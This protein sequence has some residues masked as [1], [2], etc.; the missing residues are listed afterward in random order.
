MIERTKVTKEEAAKLWF[1]SIYTKKDEMLESINNFLDK[2][3][4]VWK[5]RIMENKS[6]L[7]I[8]PLI[9]L[10]Y[11]I[12]NKKYPAYGRKIVDLLIL[13]LREFFNLDQET[14]DFYEDQ[15]DLY[16]DKYKFSVLQHENNPEYSPLEELS[17]QVLKDLLGNEV[18]KYYVEDTRVVS[19]LLCGFISTIFPVFTHFWEIFDRKYEIE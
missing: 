16:F 7:L 15:M 6:S 5:T 18:K 2:R 19:P 14:V 17:E 10:E 1:K 11:Q 4:G 13:E 9:V 3:S 12:L 8:I